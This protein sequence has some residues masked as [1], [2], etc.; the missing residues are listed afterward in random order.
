MSAKSDLADSIEA[1]INELRAQVTMA[2]GF[3]TAAEE[4][5]AQCEALGVSDSETQ[6]FHNVIANADERIISTNNLIESAELV[7][8][9]LQADG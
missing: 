1:S 4:A 5:I 3:K 9:E 8:A 6:V 7:L 2:E